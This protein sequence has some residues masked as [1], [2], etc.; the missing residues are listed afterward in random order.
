MHAFYVAGMISGLGAGVVGSH[1]FAAHLGLADA[2]GLGSLFLIVGSITR[3]VY[4]RR[5]RERHP[6]V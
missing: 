5:L 6:A 3:M 1:W 4:G 2:F